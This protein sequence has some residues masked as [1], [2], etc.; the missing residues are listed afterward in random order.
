MFLNNA[1]SSF[2]A[3]MTRHFSISPPLTSFT[4]Y[5]CQYNVV[6][7]GS[8]GSGVAP[9]PPPPFALIAICSFPSEASCL[10]SLSL[11]LSLHDSVDSRCLSSLLLTAFICACRPACTSSPRSVAPAT[12]KY[13]STVRIPPPRV[14]V[15]PAPSLAVVVV[16]VLLLV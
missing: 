16:V 10:F 15:L 13:L 5:D 3:S 12:C 6:Q 2:L 4:K 9:S 7:S 8:C 1:I 11:I 14:V